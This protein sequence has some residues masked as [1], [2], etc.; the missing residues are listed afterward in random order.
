MDEN[1]M[2]CDMFKEDKEG[3]W[4]LD[5]AGTTNCGFEL[6]LICFKDASDDPE[7]EPDAEEQ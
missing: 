3:K 1:C 4:C 2:M 5:H 7:D 6:D